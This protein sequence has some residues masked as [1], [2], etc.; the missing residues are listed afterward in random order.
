M[1]NAR[2]TFAI[3]NF[4]AEEYFLPTKEKYELKEKHVV[5]IKIFVI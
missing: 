3:D 1:Y 4:I 2:M 5:I